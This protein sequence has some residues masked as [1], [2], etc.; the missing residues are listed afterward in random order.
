MRHS[1]DQSKSRSLW[2][3]AR[4]GDW[5]TSLRSS[6]TCTFWDK[7]VET[8]SQAKHQG[9]STKTKR[10]RPTPAA[11]H[12]LLVCCLPTH[13]KAGEGRDFAMR[14]EGAAALSEV[15]ARW[16]AMTQEAEK[17]KGSKQPQQ[18]PFP[19]SCR[20]QRQR[21]KPQLNW[22]ELVLVASHR[23]VSSC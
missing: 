11:V 23:L 4:S 16:R 2:N 22:K 15:Y 7:Q 14:S 8:R 6:Q 5:D 21:R 3:Q 9:T 10:I 17:E 1:T 19:A 13:I 12:V 18:S 20:E